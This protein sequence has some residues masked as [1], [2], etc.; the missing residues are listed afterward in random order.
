ML[1]KAVHSFDSAKT[2]KDSGKECYCMSA[3]CAY[4][5]GLQ[6][7]MGLIMFRHSFNADQLY[8]WYKEY[9]NNHPYAKGNSHAFYINK[10]RE[11]I[12]TM[13]NSQVAHRLYQDLLEFKNLRE[14]A[15]YNDL[16]VDEDAI[17]QALKKAKLIKEDVPNYIRMEQNRK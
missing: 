16:L 14:R 1:D 15:A 2:L 12:K 4:Y 7:A 9:K 17:N 5:S 11:V 6:T 10:F 8:E 13:V 3:Q